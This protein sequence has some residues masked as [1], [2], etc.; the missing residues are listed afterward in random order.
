[1]CPSLSRSSLSYIYDD[2]DLGLTNLLHIP[3]QLPAISLTH[4]CSNVSPVTGCTVIDFIITD[5]QH[6]SLFHTASPLQQKHSSIN[7]SNTTITTTTKE[8]D[9]EIFYF[10]RHVNCVICAQYKTKQSSTN[11][12]GEKRWQS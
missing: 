4:D 7:E 10:S 1:M 9:Y 3:S 11:M 12:N 6:P 8:T 2:V 5:V